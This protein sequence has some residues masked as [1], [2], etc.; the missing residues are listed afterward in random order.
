M[1]VGAIIAIAVGV[2]VAGAVMDRGSDNPRYK[3][4]QHKEWNDPSNAEN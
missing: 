1:G 2:L 3:A 4:E